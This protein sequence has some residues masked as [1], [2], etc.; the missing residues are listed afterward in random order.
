[1]TEL[2][3]TLEGVGLP[4]IVRFLSGLDKTGCLRIVH[5]DWRGDVFFVRGRVVHAALGSK[6]GLAAI[7][8]LVQALPGGTFTFESGARAPAEQNVELEQ[9]AL[10]THLD[11]L[12]AST[13][14]GRAALPSLDAIPRLVAQ[15]EPGTI[16]EPLPLD[17]ATLQTLLAVD[18]QHSVGEIVAQRGSM[19]VLW[20]IANFVEVGLVHLDSP[21]PAAPASPAVPTRSVPSAAPASFATG[22]PVIGNTVTQ[23]LVDVQAFRC[24]KLGFEDDPHTSFG[25][26]TRLHRCFAASSPL[27]L[28]LDQQRE[29]CLSEQFG[30][31]P[32][33]AA[34]A[35]APT[36]WSSA[37]L[38]ARSSDEGADDS[39]IVHLPFSGRGAEAHTSAHTSAHASGNGTSTTEPP[40]LRIVAGRDAVAQPT[41]LRSR[42]QRNGAA[43]PNAR[44][45]G[46][47]VG[48]TAT[49]RPTAGAS[50]ADRVA[51]PQVDPGA[52]APVVSSGF[53]LPV[54]ALAGVAFILVVI[55]VVAA[56]LLPNLSGVFDPGVLTGDDQIDPS[57]LPNTS[58]V[59]AGTPIAQLPN[60]AARPTLAAA[61]P[62]AALA[63]AAPAANA[64][65][66]AEPTAEVAS[67]PRTLVDESFADNS[68]TWPS[69]PQGTA[70]LT[71]GAYRIAT[72][73]AGQFVA[74]GVPGVNAI[75]DTI[76]SATFHKVGGPAGGGY[77][78]IVRAQSAPDGT[79]QNGRYYV[80]ETGDKGE[81]GM[82]LR[83]NDHWVDLL[84]WQRADAVRPGTAV[85]EL[86]V[87]AIG[88]QLT[89]L[90]NGSEV[91]TRTDATLA[92]GT[93]GV[94][95]GGDGNQVAIDHLTVQTP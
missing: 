6:H 22:A 87:R 16:D 76:V 46:A 60:A 5:R 82:W 47:A 9:A 51:Q 80:L 39:R 91:A 38:G 50:P 93:P 24:P 19:D 57:L 92:A 86:T 17:R 35:S 30:T 83:D 44:P 77:G 48:S 11:D 49:A 72:R 29:L 25:R 15:D 43:A 78:L 88:S 54:Q 18:G 42:S 3:G 1:M 55:G 84:P 36:A 23:P 66:T 61:A 45:P 21:P 14:S 67:G 10:Q 40:P 85:N 56:L 7:D 94:F 81:I 33:L 69:N 12:A 74:L 2:S 8:A 58:A 34:A 73:Q 13:A 4:A 32:R 64:A 27:P 28:S 20:Q 65:P 37:P 63:N 75:A 90:V 70:W 89:L 26:P 68:R 41:P 62:T 31:C 79:T 71:G 95:V 59:V 53:R 52:A